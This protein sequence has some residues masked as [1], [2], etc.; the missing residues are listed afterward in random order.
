M[1]SR[2]HIP[3]GCRSQYIPGLSEES[4]SIYGAYKKQYM[5]NPFDGT[6]LHTGNELISKIAVEDKR[7]WE[8]MITSTALTG[9]SWK[10]WHTIRKIFN[11]PTASKPPCLVTA[12]QVAHQLPVNGR[13]E[14]PNKPKCPK[15]SPINEDAS[16][17]VFPITEYD[18]IS[19][20]HIARGVEVNTFLVCLKNRR[21]YMRHTRN[22]T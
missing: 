6:T 11:D 12:N 14:M 1:I 18:V 5:S 22:R 3:R 20:K 17:L 7:R 19:R 15:L 13:G 8:E 21:A 2:K 16:L 9:N 4:K 10:A